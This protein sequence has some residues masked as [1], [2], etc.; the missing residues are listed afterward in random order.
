V[1]ESG[2]SQL[3]ARTATL[4]RGRVLT[5][6]AA[7]FAPLAVWM[8]AVAVPATQEACGAPPLDMR[9]HYGA[10]DVTRF[11]ANCGADGI[12]AY[13]R[14]QIADLIYPA[15]LAF[16]LFIA[17]AVVM[18]RL[19]GSRSPAVLLALV[20][21]VGSVADYAENVVAWMYL[22]ASPAPFWGDLMGVAATIKTIAG[23]IGGVVLLVGLV[24]VGVRW[25][26]QRFRHS[27]V[28]A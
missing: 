18:R 13:R 16:F 9:M 6:A 2:I 20:P 3:I 24:A 25:T 23:W 17:T 10:G 28:P 1:K 15:V 14:M 22:T 8:F 11:L 12:E 19:F 21:I 26:T 7:V 27:S 5:I 4:A